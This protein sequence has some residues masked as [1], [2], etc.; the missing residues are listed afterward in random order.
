M[1]S[2]LL[3]LIGSMTITSANPPS[4]A[5][6]KQCDKPCDCKKQGSMNSSKPSTVIRSSSA[7]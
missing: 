7:V 2:K 6:S 1:H 3:E 4:L 5:L